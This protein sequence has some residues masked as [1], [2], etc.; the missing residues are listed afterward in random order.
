MEKKSNSNFQSKLRANINFF[1]TIFL[2]E[3]VILFVNRFKSTG[4]SKLCTNLHIKLLNLKN[5]ITWLIKFA[6]PA[7]QHFQKRNIQKCKNA[8]VN[9]LQYFTPDSTIMHTRQ[10]FR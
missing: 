3:K 8:F 5:Y 9:L 10:N 4:G 1:R 2:I 7:Q 6:K